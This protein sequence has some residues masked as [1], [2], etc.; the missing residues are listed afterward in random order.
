ML[1]EHRPTPRRVA[2]LSGEDALGSL[3]EAERGRAERLLNSLR[4]AVLVVLGTAAFIYAPTLPLALRHANV[5]VLAPMLGWALLQVTFS[6]GRRGRYPRWLS[7]ASPLVDT[8]ALTSILLC[9]GLIGTPAV[10]LGAPIVMVYF[11][12]LGARPVTG[13]A[14][15]AAITAAVMILEYAATIVIFVRTTHV[16][17]SVSPLAEGSAAT[18]SLLNEGMK[19][20]LLVVAGAIATYAT[21]WHERVLRRTLSAQV[22]RAAEE[23]DLTSRLQEADKLAALGTLA[24]SIAHEVNSPLAAIALSADLLKEHSPDEDVRM[25]AA[26]IAA[27]ARRTATVVRDLL[28]FARTDEAVHG[29]VVL[30]DVIEQ[31]LG[32]LRHLLRDG[33]VTVEQWLSPDLPLIGADSSALERVIINLVINA[34]QAMEGQTIQRVVRIMTD[35]DAQGISVTIEDTGPGFGPGVADHLF[36]RFFTTKPSGTGTGLGL[37]MVAQVVESHGGQITASNTGRGARFVLTIP[38]EQA[39]VSEQD[40]KSDADSR[41]STP[42]RAPHDA[43]NRRHV[44]ERSEPLRRYITPARDLDGRGSEA[45][46]AAE[47]DQYRGT[48]GRAS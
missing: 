36:E 24:A 31:G 46:D 3:L 27:D 40:A 44:A 12:I 28:A 9:Y 11:A 10:A 6:H 17:M 26:A 41:S 37:W 14:R 13:S 23:R 43:A 47:I 8:T 20:V 19:L 48:I 4:L 25:E 18:I 5:A 16:G 30:N 7:S 33:G 32:M 29:L 39:V 21:A 15:D 34:V 1:A 42:E 22:A 45:G 2:P 35:H 38:Y